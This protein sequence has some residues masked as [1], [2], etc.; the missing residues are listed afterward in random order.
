M[1]E[2]LAALVT[3]ASRGIGRGIALRL[4]REGHAVVLNSRTADPAERTRGVY[5][6]QRTIEA[7]GGKAAVFRADISS[8]EERQALVGFLDREFPRLDLLIN[9]AGIE[10]EPL[11]MLDGPEERLERVL[12]VNLK[13]PYF[14]TQALARRMIRFREQAPARVPRIVFITS[15]QAYMANPTGAEYCLSKAALHMAVK[16]FAV[17][18]GSSGI[19]VFEISPGIIE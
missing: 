5:E 11:D 6:V 7:A 10:P 9:N 12:A 18:L 14:L 3:G 13:G 2:I 8:A 4:A 19:P 17:R 15:V 1:K 16:A